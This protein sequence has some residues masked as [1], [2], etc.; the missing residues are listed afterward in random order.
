[1]DVFFGKN[2]VV[3]VFF[4]KSSCFG[5]FSLQISDIVLGLLDFFIEIFDVLE[6]GGNFEICFIVE[7]LKFDDL[8]GKIF[9]LFL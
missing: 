1:M 3:F 2:G 5:Y 7:F 9:F 6:S 8:L 4:G